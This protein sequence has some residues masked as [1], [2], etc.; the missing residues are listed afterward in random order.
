MKFDA[1]ELFDIAISE[2]RDADFVI[3]GA[4][5]F[6]QREGLMYWAEESS[7]EEYESEEEV[8]EEIRRYIKEEKAMMDN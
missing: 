5:G 6:S 2:Y 1:E 8:R 7:D 3:D 4:A